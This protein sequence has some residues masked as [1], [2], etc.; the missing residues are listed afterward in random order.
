VPT[1]RQRVHRP[2]DPDLSDW[3]AR[4]MA[5]DFVIAALMEWMHGISG[6]KS[7]MSAQDYAKVHFWVLG[8][9]EDA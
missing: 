4:E 1:P 6:D 9:E 5:P 2:I 7:D 8:D 3:V